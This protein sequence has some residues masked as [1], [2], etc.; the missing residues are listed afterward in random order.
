VGASLFGEWDLLQERVIPA[1]LETPSGA[2]RI[3]SIGEPAD[4]VAVAVAFAH[5]NAD[6]NPKGVT[7]FSSGPAGW[8]SLKFNTAELRCLPTD[9]RSALFQRRDRHWVPRPLLS[10][11]VRLGE[12]GP[13]VDLVTLRSSANP[14][15]STVPDGIVDR[16]RS[17][18]QL[19]VTDV[20]NAPHGMRAVGADDRLF[21]K[22][23]G[24]RPASGGSKDDFG[25]TLATWQLRDALVAEHIGLARSL[26]TRFTHRGESPDDLAAVA[27]LAL[28]KAARR[29]DESRGTPF[30]P[31]AAACILGELKRH[32]RDRAWSFR[33]PRP[34]QE[35]YLAAKDAR[36]EVGQQLGHSPT[37][38][39]IADYLSVS[40]ETLLEAME[41]G[42]NYRADSLDIQAPDDERPHDI[43]V[44]DPSFDQ[45]LDRERLRQL[46]PTLERR[47]QIVLKRLFF[48]DKTQ[49]EVADELGVSQMQI[50][51]MLA[52][53]VNKLRR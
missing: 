44:V 23:A 18:G 1:L 32:F 16:L 19:L 51:R 37:V 22:E 45:V 42:T 38:A 30:A 52:R 40:E 17:G 3:W 7:V 21:Y 25:P 35:L 50:S 26:A 5:A 6:R 46:A 9:E 12:P 29:Y 48:D 4:A 24:H 33:V 43:G 20:K 8:E 2:A 39:Q 10:K 41:A 36:E 47:E 13:P 34:M 49:L 53:I 14:D 11:N 27:Q 31:Y 15:P 28:V